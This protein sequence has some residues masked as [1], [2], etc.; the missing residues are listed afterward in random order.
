VRAATAGRPR[1]EAED[2]TR[3]KSDPSDAVLIARLVGELRCYPPEHADQ[4]WARL[5][6]L[7]TR[8][9]QLTTQVTAARQQLRDLLE[10]AWPAVLQAAAR[11]LERVRLTLDD[12][13]HTLGQLDPARR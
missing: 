3:A 2:Y 8:R 13:H 5:R 4:V 1:R 9:A 12:W 11:R 6:Q 7:G 10:C